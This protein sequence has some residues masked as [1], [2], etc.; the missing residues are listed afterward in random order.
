[1]WMEKR[2]G[3][4]FNLGEL[5]WISHKKMIYVGSLLRLNRICGVDTL[6]SKIQELVTSFVHMQWREWEQIIT[7]QMKDMEL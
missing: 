5:S 3:L 7:C 4:L 1:M 2:N 6:H